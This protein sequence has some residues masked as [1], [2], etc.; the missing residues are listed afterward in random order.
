LRLNLA[1]PFSKKL[2][3]HWQSTA[4]QKTVRSWWKAAT[5][6]NP[7]PTLPLNVNSQIN[8][9]CFAHHWFEIYILAIGLIHVAAFELS[10]SIINMSERARVCARS[11]HWQS[12]S[13]ECGYKIVCVSNKVCTYENIFKTFL[14]IE[15]YWIGSVKKQILWCS[16]YKYSANFCSVK[17]INLTTNWFSI[18]YDHFGGTIF[19]KVHR[20]YNFILKLRNTACDNP[21]L[22]YVQILLQILLRHLRTCKYC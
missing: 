2:V 22:N 20:R 12:I 21:V 16:Y 5:W 13:F 15:K 7:I 9:V 1:C 4:G 11:I 19:Q 10:T 8:G 18:I 3:D 17:V 6:I 14:Y